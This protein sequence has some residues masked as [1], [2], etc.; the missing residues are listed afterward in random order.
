MVKYMNQKKWRN[1]ITAISDPNHEIA[2]G[3]ISGKSTMKR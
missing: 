2:V 3:Y 1:E